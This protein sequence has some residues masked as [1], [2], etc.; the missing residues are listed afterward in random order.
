[1]A[2]LGSRQDYSPAEAL[3]PFQGES[4]L[5]AHRASQKWYVASWNVRTLLDVEGS[6]ETARGFGDVSV[7][8]E[9]KVVQVLSELDR[10]GVVVVGLQETKWFGSKIYKVGKSVIL[11][12]GRDVPKEGGSRQ[13]DARPQAAKGDAVQLAATTPTQMWPKEKMEVC[14]EKRPQKC[15]SGGT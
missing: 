14:G 10:Y 11:S 1:M 13:R 7:V 4:S 12:S 8:D 3:H 15:G 2:P 6:I 9:R 5:G